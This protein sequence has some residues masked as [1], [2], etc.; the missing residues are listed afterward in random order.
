MAGCYFY[1][2]CHDP[3]FVQDYLFRREVQGTFGGAFAVR[4][5]FVRE[6][7][8]A[9]L[10][11]AG[12]QDFPTCWTAAVAGFASFDVSDGYELAMIV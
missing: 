6:M 11:L 8:G 12:D 10:A 5:T 4:T 1:G 9:Y 7:P 2:R 3:R